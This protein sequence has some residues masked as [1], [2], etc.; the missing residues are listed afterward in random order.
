MLKDTSP[1]SG[2]VSRYAET[3]AK[4]PIAFVGAVFFMMFWV[5]YFINIYAKSEDCSY[6]RIQYEV[7]R[8]KNDK[9]NTQLLIQNGIIQ[10]QGKQMKTEDSIIRSETKHQVERLLKYEKP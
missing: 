7:E 4:N 1:N 9:L 10:I 3:I 5:T 8:K 6:W 2:K